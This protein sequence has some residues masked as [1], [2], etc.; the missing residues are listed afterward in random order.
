MF[1]IYKTLRPV[2][3]SMDAEKAHGLAIKAMRCG[4]MPKPPKHED[5]ALE[6]TLW[7]LKFP[8]PIGLA[9]GFDKNAEVIGPAFNLGFGF[10]ETGTVTPKPQEGN[11]K[12]RIFRDVA[13]QAIINRMGFPNGGA[14]AYKANLEKFLAS[15]KKPQGV[16]GLNIGMNKTQK[17]PVKDYAYL[18]RLLAPMSDY[19]TVN[20]S[21][22]NTPGLRDL[23]KREPLTELLD[24][25]KQERAKACRTHT[26]PLFVKLAPD[27]DEAQQEELCQTLMDTGID[28][29]ILT[30]TTLD[31][32]N[33]MPQHIQ[34]EAGGLSGQPLS[35]KSTQIIHNF[36]A[37]SKGKLPII[38]VGGVSN[39]V[40]A[41]NKIRAGASLLQLYTALVYVGPMVAHTICTELSGMLKNDGFS[42]I[43]EAV[44]AD[45]R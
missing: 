40:Q 45:H 16:V 32:P 12:P 4:A 43:S 9:A 6:Q 33:T 29:V 38:G 24:A 10:V 21:S 28:G 31:R 1:D 11:P 35:E 39:G 22:P 37:L 5:P 27:L 15:P 8:N 13:N 41:Y 2:L 17:N 7:G 18:I 44:G 30:N 42:N 3:F 36:Y 14:E 19:L 34:T 20:I 26:P 23:Q 25:I